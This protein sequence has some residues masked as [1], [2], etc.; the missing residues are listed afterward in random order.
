MKKPLIKIKHQLLLMCLGLLPFLFG[1]ICS[2]AKIN[3]FYF[4]S[5]INKAISLYT[6]AIISFMS[7]AV[8]GKTLVINSS[9]KSYLSID[10]NGTGKYFYLSNIITLVTWGGIIFTPNYQA[11]YKISSLCFA[12][13]LFIDWQLLNLRVIEKSYF[14]FRCKITAGVLVCLMIFIINST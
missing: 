4:I 5:D 11:F 3:E 6:L 1:V 13:L 14:K 2:L 10:L 7:G 9:D 12:F 8:W